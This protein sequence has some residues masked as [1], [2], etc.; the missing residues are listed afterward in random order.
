M[1]YFGL[2]GLSIG[3]AIGLAALGGGAGLGRA[4]SS[5][6]EGTAR[7]PESSGELRTTLIIGAALIEA[8]TIY[9]L[10]IGILLLGKLPNSAEMLEVIKAI[11]A[12]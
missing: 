2:I 8:L 4:T 10:V 3:L 12:N 6:L 1:W 5:A 9:S 11:G 7:Q